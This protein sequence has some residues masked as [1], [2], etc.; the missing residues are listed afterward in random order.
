MKGFK[1]IKYDGKDFVIAERIKVDGKEAYVILEQDYLAEYTINGVDGKD[2]L[3]I[4]DYTPYDGMAYNII[5]ND[6]GK[7]I[8]FYGIDIK[9]SKIKEIRSSNL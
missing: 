2:N 7:G 3:L 8:G 9:D 1:K 4:I 5:D 6:T